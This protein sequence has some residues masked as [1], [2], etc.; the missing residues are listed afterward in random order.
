MRRW[1]FYLILI[2]AIA[3]GTSGCGKSA[4]STVVL[5]ISPASSSVVTN[6]TLQFTPTITGTSNLTVTWTIACAT[7]V[8][9]GSCGTIDSNGLYTAPKIVPTTTSNGTTTIAPT[10]TITAT[11]QA[12]TGK[13]A[14]STITII[15][16]ISISI[17]PTTATIGTG[18]HFTF[19]ATV[20][21]PGCNTITNP[22]C[23]NVTWSV[24]TAVTGVGS[25]DANGVYT[26]PASV[27]SP[28]TVTLTA[29]SVADTSVTATAAVTIV[30]ASVPTVGAV[31][32]STAGLGSLF[33]DI[34]ITGTNFI[35]T[36]NV[37]VNG[38]QLNPALVAEVS[39]SVIRARIPDYILASPPP[40][41]FL[42]IGV[43]QQT[44]SL[45]NC[46]DISQCQVAVKGVRP[47]VVGPSPD[48]ISQGAAGV[49]SFDIDG[50]F[51][52]TAANPAVSATYGGQ[53]RAIQGQPSGTARSTRQLSVTIGGSSNSADF[54]IPG[55]YPVAVRSALDS[56]KF[57]V[58][59]LA[60]QPNYNITSITTI[61][62]RIAVGSVPASS[63]PSDVAI[64]PATGMA[65]V[66]NTGSNDVSLVDLTQA[67]P[68]VVAT[69]CTAAVGATVPCPASG[70]SS[71]SVDYVRNIALVVNTAAKT[72]A[73]VDLNAKALTYVTPALQDSPGAVGI[74]PVSGRALVA[75]Q[76]RNYG[77]LMDVTQ[78]PPVL[79]G[80]VSIS[81]GPH[82]RVAVEP[83]LNWAI[84][85]PGLAGSVGIVDLNRQTTNNI[86]G[87]SR[88]TNVVTVTIQPSTTAVPQSPLAVQSGD[89]VQIQGASDNS[90]NG[91]YAVTAIGPGS[92]QFTFTQTAAT[93][94][95]V[96][97]FA[98]AG[99]VNYSDPVA[100]VGLS[101]SVQ[102]I[103]IN[104]ETQQAVLV[105]PTSNGVVSFFSL[106]DQSVVGLQLKTNNAVEPGTVGAAFNSLT[107]TAIAVNFTDNTLSVLDPTTPS[108]LNEGNLYNTQAGPVAV[109]VD[110]GTN[111][112]VVANQTDNSITVLSLGAIQSV[113]ITETSPKVFVANSTLTTA[114]VPSALTLTIL[115]KGF[116]SG[117]PVA[118]LDGISLSTTVVS[119]R[120]L[121]A[122]VPPSLL[123][124]ARRFALDVQISNG[125]VTNAEDFTVQQS[126]DVTGCSATPFPSG[127]AIDAQQNIAAVTLSGCN[128][129]ALINLANGT[130]QTVGVGN[131]PQ[132]VAVDSRL[133][134]AAVANNGDGTASLV[135]ELGAS[136]TNTI[137][138]GTGP[139][140]VAADQDTGQVAVANSVANTVSIISSQGGVTSIT[141][142][143]RPIAVAFNFQNHQVAIATTG[144]TSFNTGSVV[145]A[146]AAAAAA[147]ASFSVNTPTSVVYDPWVGD[148]PANNTV[149]CFLANSSTNNN[150]VILDPTTSSETPF[151]I[152]INPTAIAYNYLT[153]TLVSTNTL[154]HTV[155]VAD[156]LAQRIR[157]VLT[158]PPAP[159]NS[160]LA[161]TGSLQFGLDVHPLTNLA[162]IAD[163]ANGRV[164]FIPLP[165]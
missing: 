117:S 64:N 2:L 5:N 160:N 113:S 70:P 67:T 60:V 140:G 62:A 12:D 11:S 123:S 92:T 143:Q 84:A 46:A 74:N 155:T 61:A 48:T 107:N 33:Q 86:T 162:V 63:A 129:L 72:I 142:G 37:Y 39:S 121:T 24:P 156:F 19:V 77:I 152:G 45:Q 89:A 22:T 96:A 65:V 126:V 120:K 134:I 163:T 150:V 55:L 79:I 106:I 81:T 122:I 25:I 85:T 56:T 137:T 6:T 13:T 14:V 119:D 135:D 16:G 157:A 54:T 124:S 83:H 161:L 47:A 148:C 27:P 17:L 32:P 20:N 118:R 50:G 9:A 82:T 30:T 159:V 38:S 7:N 112:A 31:S 23:L 145:F 147:N 144:A 34:Y 133:H 4:T 165:R 3:T 109:A 127:V 131:N 164:L 71:V 99:T 125:T 36:N 100:T 8:T 130:G 29:T 73:V 94:P 91:I 78:N 52:G 98:T 21:N 90:F 128:S 80:P 51:F 95:D 88:T 136:V 93:L 102:G 1:T 69:I 101:T 103:G 42:Q 53:L 146:N 40:S 138:T 35:S 87:L 28:S 104:T 97:S 114:P 105:D 141:T 75:M 158:L 110:P 10:A 66:A 49:L 44:G 153:S 151:R 43:S 132:G 111:I 154:S 149:G 59:N 76:Q 139:M 15:S 41:G 57:A 68:T 18:E 108:R 115:G 116:A 58:A 26:A